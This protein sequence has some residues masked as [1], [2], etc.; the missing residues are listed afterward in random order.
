MC[1]SSEMVLF[2]EKEQSP[3]ALQHPGAHTKGLPESAEQAVI[4][5]S[6]GNNEQITANTR[7]SGSLL[8]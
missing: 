7:N 3:I 1:Q 5:A 4:L 2:P 8:S 6:K